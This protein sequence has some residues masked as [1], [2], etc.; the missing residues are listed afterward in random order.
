M[1]KQRTENEGMLVIGSEQLEC[2]D[3][4]EIDPRFPC[5]LVEPLYKQVDIKAKTQKAL[6]TAVEATIS[7]V[8]R[9]AV[10]GS[11]EKAGS[12]ALRVAGNQKDVRVRLCVVFANTSKS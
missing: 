10:E 8:M 11:P 12:I 2:R 7:A 4:R 5:E 1:A 9:A 6:W 3:C